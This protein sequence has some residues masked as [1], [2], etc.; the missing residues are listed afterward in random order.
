MTRQAGGWTYVK[1]DEWIDGQ[2]DV[3]RW[4]VGGWIGR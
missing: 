1:G 3:D 4:V 2:M